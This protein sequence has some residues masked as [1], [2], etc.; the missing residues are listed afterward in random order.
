MAACDQQGGGSTHTVHPKAWQIVCLAA[1]RDLEMGVH[2]VCD[3]CML[4]SA[5]ACCQTD[6]ALRV[7][8]GGSSYEPVCFRGP[9]TILPLQN[10]KSQRCVKPWQ[11]QQSK[12]KVTP[13][14]MRHGPPPHTHS[15]PKLPPAMVTAV[16]T[17]FTQHLSCSLGCMHHHRQ[18]PRT[19]SRM[20]VLLSVSHDTGCIRHHRPPI[21]YQGA[22]RMGRPSA[23][24]MA[25][26]CCV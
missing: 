2:A 22:T 25:G 13:C 11:Q 5:N 17:H 4:A 16:H 3:R 14:A 9:P 10:H 24:H 19:S 6:A 23:A 12:A 18:L 8:S 7:V 1:C 15:D 26:Q 21:V 20:L